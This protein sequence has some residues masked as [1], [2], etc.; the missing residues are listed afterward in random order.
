MKIIEKANTLL[1][2]GKLIAI[3]TETVYGLAA[4]AS[5]PE[6]VR[7]IFHTKGRP[8]GHPLIIHVSSIE[9]AKEWC[10]WTEKAQILAQKFWPGPLTLIVKKKPHVLDEVTGGLSSIGIR[11]PNHPTTLAL[12]ELFGGALAAP[13]ANRFGKVSPTTAAHVVEEFGEDIFVLDGGP[14]SIGVESSIVDL[15][16]GPALLRPG[17][18][19][20]EE[21]QAHIG[22]LGSSSTPASGTLKAHYAPNTA[23]FI[24]DQPYK[25]AQRL[26]AQGKSVAILEESSNIE[27][28]KKLYAELRR[29]DKEEHDVL[30]VRRATADDL[31]IAINDR[32]T[33][34]AYGAPFSQSKGK[35]I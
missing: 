33:R 16:S 20:K 31:G 21:I 25:E 17:A 19:S 27:Y 29:L 24:C 22:T 1:R 5:N 23:V 6:A 35:K 18:I 32:L 9:K 30:I 7:R 26:R 12:L 10:F 14:C 34:A 15:Y 2:E 4:D 8:S 3:P 28:A 11:V 13:S